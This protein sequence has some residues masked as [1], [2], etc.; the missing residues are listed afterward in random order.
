ALDAGRLA[1]D[2][3]GHDIPR[4]DAIGRRT[5]IGNLSISVEKFSDDFELCGC[6]AAGRT[7]PST[8]SGWR[9]ELKF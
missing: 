2:G 8:S 5:S 6:L 4:D 1:V 3:N 7:P 9:P